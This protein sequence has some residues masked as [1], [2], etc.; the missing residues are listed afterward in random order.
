MS[1][2]ISQLV[3]RFRK[4]LGETQDQFG[5][6]YGVTGPA[7]YKL[8]KGYI[9]PK[10]STW[11]RMAN[12]MGIPP[13]RA[14]LIWVRNHL[15]KQLRDGLGVKK[16]PVT[17]KTKFSHIKNN[18]RLREALAADT[19]V[20]PGLVKFAESDEWTLYSPTGEEIDLLFDIFG[21]T[22]GASIRTVREALQL[23]REF[24]GEKGV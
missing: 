9:L 4:K 17:K 20:P 18:V 10:I 14:V 6:R 12:D 5:V 7:I 22:H 3:L 16:P 24:Q 15:P 13:R 2:L 8:E 1:R 11:L 19:S 21:A 23:L